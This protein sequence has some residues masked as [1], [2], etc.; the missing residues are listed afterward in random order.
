MCSHFMK[1]KSQTPTD[2]R[3][4][5]LRQVSSLTRDLFTRTAFALMASLDQMRTAS[6][7]WLPFL[8]LKPNWSFELCE[9]LQ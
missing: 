7:H 4:I 3:T 2:E 8:K 9:L 6:S 5:D 1:N